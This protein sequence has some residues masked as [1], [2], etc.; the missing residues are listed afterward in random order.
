VPI[1]R[2]H[3]YTLWIGGPVSPGA[4]ATTFG[5]WILVRRGKE[6]D[7]LLLRHE[8]VHVEQ[9][10]RLGVPGFLVR[11]LASYLGFRLRGLPH[12]AAYRRIPFEI[13]AEWQAR[14]STESRD[15]AAPAT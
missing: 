3:G 2:R 7:P 12:W 10:R 4:S 9:Y 11:Y 8:L 6:R 1:E 13:E 5:S 15:K 14:R